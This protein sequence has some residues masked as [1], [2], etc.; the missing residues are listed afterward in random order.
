MPRVRN[1]RKAIGGSKSE[2]MIGGASVAVAGV[3]SCFIRP[4][5]KTGFDRKTDPAR[6]GLAGVGHVWKT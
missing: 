1:G 2:E 6:M 5:F 4:S 3:R